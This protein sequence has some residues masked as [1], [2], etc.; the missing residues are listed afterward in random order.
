MKTLDQ[1]FDDIALTELRK[2]MNRE[3]KP[4]EIIN[5]DKDSDLVNEVM[6]QLVKDLEG[7]I[8]ALEKKK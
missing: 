2:R 8:K 6:W 4:N 7:R 3:P 5:G 1:Q